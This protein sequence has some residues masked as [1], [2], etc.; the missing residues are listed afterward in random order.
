MTD[1][2]DNVI[3]NMDTVENV[4]INNK[5]LKVYS[6]KTTIAEKLKY[7]KRVIYHRPRVRYKVEDEQHGTVKKYTSTEIHNYMKANNMTE[8][9]DLTFPLV[10]E[11]NITDSTP[12]LKPAEN[13]FIGLFNRFFNEGIKFHHVF[14]FKTTG[15]R[16]RIKL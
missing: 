6:D 16:S 1:G 12:V 11:Q 4:F 2:A 9:E 10:T 15:N 14:E 3:D 7:D 5:P 13:K 8:E